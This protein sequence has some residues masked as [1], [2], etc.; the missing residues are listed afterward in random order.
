VIATIA[1]GERLD[2]A[3]VRTLQGGIAAAVADSARAIVIEG[4]PGRFCLGMDFATLDVTGDP[5]RLR[6][7][8]GMLHALLTVPIPT[9]AII[10]GPALGGGLGV[11][12]ACDVVLASDRA[13]VG[14]PE[15]LYGLAPAII[16]PALLTRLSPQ[17]L[18]MLVVTCHS[19]SPEEGRA[20]GLVDEVVAVA[21]LAAATTRI[22][23]QL[24]RASGDTVAALRR[25]DAE[26]LARAL[27]AGVEETGAA[28]A[29]PAVRDAIAAEDPSWA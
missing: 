1:I 11:A 15:A 5:A 12:A 23:R 14:L 13:R 6:G 10:D 8:A 3:C 27:A 26:D 28:L 2:E 4:V 24:R 19:R 9:L 22:V 25:W 18:R 20:L 21:A 17:Q 16:R 7:F 29:R